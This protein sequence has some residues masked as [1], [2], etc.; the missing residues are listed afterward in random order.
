MNRR[1][2]LQG[3]AA[4]GVST[5]VSRIALADGSAVAGSTTADYGRLLVL[6]ELKGGNDGLNTVVP[7]ENALYYNKR[8]SIAIKK[9]SVL[10]LNSQMGLNPAMSALKGL[11]DT[12][13]MSI[14]QNVGYP[15]PNRSHFRSTDIWLT[16]SEAVKFHNVVD[17]SCLYFGSNLVFYF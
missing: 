3:I 7:Y 1:K 14:V 13:K 2:L 8:A 10:P 12:G 9:E 5:L 16:A 6:I 15:S 17:T 4:C 11:Y